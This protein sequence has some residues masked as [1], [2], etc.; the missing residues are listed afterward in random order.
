MCAWLLMVGRALANFSILHRA[1]ACAVLAASGLVLPARLAA[2]Q[3]TTP[4]QHVV[5][6]MQ[7]NRSFDNYFGTYPG[8]DGFPAGTCVP[9]DPANPLAGCVA[10]FHDPNNSNAGGPAHA[11]RGRRRHR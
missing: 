1:A 2:A 3:S 5:V 11:E 7:E 9:L 4:I 8:A 6:I 10:P